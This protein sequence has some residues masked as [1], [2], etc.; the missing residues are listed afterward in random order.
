MKTIF[1]LLFIINSF[2]FVYTQATNNSKDA[3]RIAIAPY[4]SDQIANFPN[5]AKNLLNQKLN[6]IVTS[7]GMSGSANLE[8]F[9]ITANVAITNK[10]IKYYIYNNIIWN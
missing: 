3:A 7:Q 8:R 1:I 10:D 2:G 6:Q 5:E 9:I 4:V